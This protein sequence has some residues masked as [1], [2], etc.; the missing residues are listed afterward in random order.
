MKISEGNFI[1]E[2]KFLDIH[3]QTHNIQADIFLQ[4]SHQ[5]QAYQ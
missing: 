5:E 1:F 3:P 2:L 4:I